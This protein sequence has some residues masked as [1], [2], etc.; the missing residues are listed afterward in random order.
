MICDLSVAVPSDAIQHCRVLGVP[1]CL[2]LSPVVGRGLWE[3]LFEV[4]KKVGSGV[5]Q[6][7]NLSIYFLYR[8]RL[9]LIS[10]QNFKELLINVGLLGVT[11]LQSRLVT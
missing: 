4:L 2:L 3:K 11:I 10:L 9:S 1:G 5:E 8:F 7:S 6:I